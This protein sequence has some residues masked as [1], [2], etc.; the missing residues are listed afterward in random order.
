MTDTNTASKLAANGY[1]PVPST[2]HHGHGSTGHTWAVLGF[3]PLLKLKDGKRVRIDYAPELNV[4][5]ITLEYASWRGW[6]ESFSPVAARLADA[7]ADALTPTVEPKRGLLRR[8]EEPKPRPLIR[9]TP[10][11][12]QLV[13]R[14][15]GVAAELRDLTLHHRPLLY[16]HGL[17]ASDASAVLTLSAG[18]PSVPVDDG[19]AWADARSPLTVARNTLPTWN[20]E[21]ASAAVAGLVDQWVAAGDLRICDR[22]AEPPK[23]EGYYGHEATLARQ[24]VTL[25]RAVDSWTGKSPGDLGRERGR[26]G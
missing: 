25:G 14:I 16:P 20:G 12:L 18:L 19:A 15:D 23:P 26:F 21:A 11:S 9:R 8:R 24:G 3:H 17:A 7:L 2:V 6:P 22:Y 4:A 13:Y 10:T 5:S 1:E